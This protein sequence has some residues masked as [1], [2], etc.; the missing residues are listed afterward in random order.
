MPICRVVYL[1]RKSEFAEVYEDV[2][3]RFYKRE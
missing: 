2:R 1:L 3:L